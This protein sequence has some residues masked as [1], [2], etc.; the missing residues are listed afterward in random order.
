MIACIVS[1]KTKILATLR[2]AA[3]L[4]AFERNIF[5]WEWR[6]FETAYRKCGWKF[7][8]E[9]TFQIVNAGCKLETSIRFTLERKRY[10]LKE[11]TPFNALEITQ[12]QQAFVKTLL[13][14]AA[15]FNLSYSYGSCQ[16]RSRQEFLC[17]LILTLF[18]YCFSVLFPLAETCKF[19]APEHKIRWSENVQPQM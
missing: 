1:V 8:L 6:S 5:S 14:K 7:A 4:H 16:K 18:F 19:Y 15:T 17:Y 10:R 12:I 3:R 9:W 2:K 13:I 11:F